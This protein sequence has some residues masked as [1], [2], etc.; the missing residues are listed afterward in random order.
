MSR[1]SPWSCVAIASMHFLTYVSLVAHAIAA[2]ANGDTLTV[3]Q[4]SI[5]HILGAPLM[6]LARMFPGG[7][8]AAVALA[9]ANS[10]LWAVALTGAFAVSRR[11]FRR[12]QKNA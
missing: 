10:S 1:L 9:A 8:S 2:D 5:I 6:P 4:S 11:A 7:T 12:H 3:S